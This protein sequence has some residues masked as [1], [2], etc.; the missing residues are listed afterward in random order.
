MSDE[1]FN[2]LLETIRSEYNPPPETPRVEMWSVIQERIQGGAAR[3]QGGVARTQSG[4]AEELKPGPGTAAEETKGSKS[5]VVLSLDQAR[6]DRNA[7]IRRG[8]TWAMGA[9][10]LLILGL[11]IGRM[12]DPGAP[13]SKK[14]VPDAPSVSTRAAAGRSGDSDPLRVVSLEHLART[15]SLLILARA[16]ARAGGVEA[17]VGGWSRSLLAQTRLLL[18]AQGGSD[19]VLRELLEDLELVLVQLVGASAMEGDSA[20]IQSEWNLALEGLEDTEVLSRIRAVL[21]TGARFM[22]T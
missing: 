12:T 17:G 1:N 5:G 14:G 15:E 10:A 20:K 18:D 3:I 8:L 4:A 16:D 7:R 21:P 13:A 19:P 6:Q 22:G 9:A 2:H 11:G